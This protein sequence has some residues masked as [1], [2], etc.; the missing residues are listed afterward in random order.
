ML[1]GA[2]FCSGSVPT[3]SSPPRQSNTAFEPLFVGVA[4][5]QFTW[6]LAGLTRRGLSQVGY[7]PSSGA[8]LPCPS[9]IVL[10]FQPLCL[11][12]GLVSVKNKFIKIHFH[13]KPLSSKNQFHQKTNF[14][15]NHFHQ[16]PFPS[17]TT[18]IGDHHHKRNNNKVRVCVKASRAFGP[19]RLH[20]N[21][22]FAHLWGLSRPFC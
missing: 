1:W 9:E 10:R 17:K 4:S 12:D 7:C 2:E 6:N 8:S 5:P 15:K 20:T 21:K 14:I 22:A 19:R 11:F 3:V 18:F 16:K 13:Q